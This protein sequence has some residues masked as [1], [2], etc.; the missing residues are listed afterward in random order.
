MQQKIWMTLSSK[1]SDGKDSIIIKEGD[2]F[3]LGKI[4]FEVLKVRVYFMSLMI[5]QFI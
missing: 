3:K 2:F 5:F 1:L 4:M